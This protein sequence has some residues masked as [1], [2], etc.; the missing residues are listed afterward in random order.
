MLWSKKKT[1][2]SDPWN[3]FKNGFYAPEN[4]YFDVSYVNERQFY[5]LFNKM[6]TVVA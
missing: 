5:D 4:P 1:E 2:C 6:P 3:D